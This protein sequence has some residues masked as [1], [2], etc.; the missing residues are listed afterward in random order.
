M[1]FP[2]LG[3]C[4]ALSSLWLVRVSTIR[5]IT[6]I[7]ATLV[8]SLLVAAHADAI[9]IDDFGDGAAA[10]H[11]EIGDPKFTNVQSRLDP[12]SVIGGSRLIEFHALA[13]PKGSLGGVSIQV[14]PDLG[15]LQYA[16]DPSITAVNLAIRYGSPAQPLNANFAAGGADRIRFEFLSTQLTSGLGNVGHF[17]VRVVTLHDTLGTWSGG[18]SLIIPSSTTPLSLEIPFTEI[19]RGQPYALDFSRVVAFDFGSSNGNLFGSF[20]LDSICTV[21]EPST[22]A[23]AVVGVAL[24]TWG[25]RNACGLVRRR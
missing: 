19:Q 10:M 11:R 9:V 12:A 5:T 6:S 22:L 8:A 20:L 21:P 2:L 23:I 4:R 18:A 16:S 13:R 3:C 15:Q 17:D 1:I 7:V 25:W 24:A 14:D